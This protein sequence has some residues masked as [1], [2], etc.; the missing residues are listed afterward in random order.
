MKKKHCDKSKIKKED[1]ERKQQLVSS[2]LQNKKKKKNN[3]IFRR[4]KKIKAIWRNEV[5]GQ[6]GGGGRNENTQEK[7]I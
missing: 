3:A 2:N 7:K 4:K 6:E 1:H 5:D